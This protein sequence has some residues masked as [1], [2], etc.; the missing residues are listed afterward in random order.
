[1]QN[2]KR[3][4]KNSSKKTDIFVLLLKWFVPE[5]KNKDEKYLDL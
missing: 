3:L 4:D 1:M 2:F 5:M